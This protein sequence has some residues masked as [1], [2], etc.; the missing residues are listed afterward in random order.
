MLLKLPQGIEDTDTPISD[1][2]LEVFL[3]AYIILRNLV[4]TSVHM[5][6]VL[7][8]LSHLSTMVVAF[9]PLVAVG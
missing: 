7:L 1:I 2:S 5:V 8:Q 9:R 6:H 3:L 4:R